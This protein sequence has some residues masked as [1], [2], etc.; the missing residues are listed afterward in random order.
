MAYIDKYTHE[1]LQASGTTATAN[2]PDHETDDLVVIFCTPKFSTFTT[3]TD[4]TLEEDCTNDGHMYLWTYVAGAT[5]KTSITMTAGSSGTSFSICCIVVKE[6]PTS[7]YVDLSAQKSSTAAQDCVVPSITT[8]VADCL[9]I[10]AAGASTTPQN[11]QAPCLGPGY[12][13]LGEASNDSQR[14][15][16]V[17]WTYQKSAGA[18]P[19]FDFPVSEY[20]VSNTSF[21]GIVVA[22]KDKGNS[23]YPGY[24]KCD[25]DANKPSTLVSRHGSRFEWGDKA[26]AVFNPTS[27]WSTINSTST[28]YDGD[29]GGQNFYILDDQRNPRMSSLT[30]DQYIMGGSD[31]TTA[32]DLS[33]S[34]L[35][36]TIAHVGTEYS[37]FAQPTLL[38]GLSNGTYGRLWDI[39]GSDTVPRLDRGIFPSTFEVDGGFE[40]SSADIGT[41][42]SAS[43]DKTVVAFYNNKTNDKWHIGALHKLQTLIMLG[44]SSTLPCSMTDA[45]KMIVACQ[46]NT[47][48]NQVGQSATQF[49]VMQ[50][51]TIGDGGTT[52]IY[53]DSTAQAIEFP[54]A[55]DETSA[56][57][58]VQNQISSA[59]L[60]LEVD[61][62]TGKTVKLGSLDMGDFH[63]ILITSGAVEVD[64]AV[65]RNSTPTIGTTDSAL[66]NL[67]I[68]ASKQLTL[69]GDIS[70]GG[71]VIDNCDDT[72]AVVVTSE[73]EFNAL[74][75]VDFTNNNYSIRIT[76]NHGGDTWIATGMTVSGGTGSYDIRYEGTGT[77]TIEVDTGS[78][79]TQ[80]R[81]EATTGTLTISAPTLSFT[82]NSSESGSD[83]KIFDT[84]TQTI[85]ASATGTTV[86]TT[87]TGTYDWTV[88]KAGFL[89]QRGTGVALSTSSVSVDV[90]LVEDPVYNASHGLTF[91]TDYSYTPATRILTIVAN[92]EGRDL[93]SALID[94]FISETSLRNVPFPLKA[95]GPDRIDFQAV[96][97][98]SSST[99]VGATIDSG[100]I[101]FWKGAGMEWEHD[102][103]GNPTKKFYS[104]KSANTLQ[105]GSVVGYTQVNNGTATETT[106][107]SDKVNE[108][109]QYFEDTDGNGTADYDYT[110]HLL[111][112]GFKTGFYQ[113]RWDVIND[114]GVS[115]L[116]SYEYVIN[117]IQDAI[118]G[119]TG[120]QSVTITTLTDHTS[121]PLSVGGKSFDYEL[122]DPASTT[123][124]DLLAQYNYDVFNA[125]DTSITSTLY[126]SYN[127]FDLPDL[128]IE[129]G[130]NYESERGYF[131]GDGAVT[132]LSGV[133][134]S[135]SGD[136]PDVARF[137]S[138]DGTYYTP[139]TVA[140]ISAPNITGTNR[141][142]IYNESAESFSAW[143][144]S[145]VYAEGA[146]VLRTTGQGTELG[147]G[148]F[149]VCT[150]AGTSGGSEPTWDVAADGNTTSDN[151]VT[152]TVRP[153]EFDNTSNVGAYSNTYT[154]GTYFTSG[155]T[156]RFRCTQT[157]KL[158]I[159]SSGVATAAGT[160]TFLDSATTDDVYVDSGLTG[161]DYTS[162]FSADY[163]DT[164]IDV[165]I[166]SNFQAIEMY[167]WFQYIL[168][169]EDGIRQF[170]GG[171]TAIDDSNFRINNGDVD[172]YFDNTTI[173]NIRQT[174]NRR[175]YRADEVYPVKGGGATTGGG[176]IDLVW[177]DKVFLKETGTSG[178]TA[179]ESSQLNSISTVE[180]KIDTVDTVVDAILVDTT[181][182]ETKVD[183]IDTNV[184]SI[185]IDTGTDIP[186]LIAAVQT[187]VDDIIADTGSTLP[188]QLSAISI[189]TTA[190]NT[191]VDQILTD[192]DVTIP[193]LISA[194]NDF[195]PS[196]DTLEG[197][198]T[199]DQTLRILRS[200]LAGKN[201]KVGNT[202]TFRDAADTKDRVSSEVV[203]KIRTSVTTDGT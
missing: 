120:D 151:T 102:T 53:W 141:I 192:T 155:D 190:T 164:E 160:T 36:I 183:T 50:D 172:V 142:Q 19:T 33:G 90:T 121:S 109:I 144:A 17:G 21:N 99:T 9:I 34:I 78:G 46:L 100:D 195:N 22:I 166:G 64:N 114:S 44:G 113:A 86:N 66:S 85:E 45:Q 23:Y 158:G 125:V 187:V 148:V 188:T 162:K 29:G 77:L 48:Q 73:S 10:A 119:T 115:S 96:G 26:Q 11:N 15:Q 197:S 6:A 156:I 37:A 146:R 130:A 143:A 62:G 60:T 131:E 122:V 108:V 72:Y 106:L 18:T 67:T 32:V 157:G 116:E 136:H 35:A 4:F 171:V 87:S 103:T 69:T 185:L 84:T 55:P 169:T 13:Y 79:W 173:T 196:S 105:T 154:N 1:D 118:A 107:V 75:N 93:Y 54:S 2:L 202:E 91:T 165:I 16:A 126:T 145:T 58:R 52:D 132:D 167:T 89:P 8:T 117:L 176:G 203:D 49:F 139:D 129:A 31:L 174:D 81:A 5:P 135:R 200:V 182:I 68:T 3:P 40:Y 150:G 20:R 201:N 186:A 70:G 71:C 184:D 101:Q 97:T 111:F 43:I 59:A 94:D 153:L 27:V 28:T 191:V 83:L 181:S 175:V 128:I 63:N 112:K 39:A 177:R 127:A 65:W 80:P 42:N 194:L 199:Y 198:E 161:S 179:S 123:A 12:G 88:Q 56:P 104:V 133:Y 47:I 30:A 92:Q 82:L 38:V 178:L 61:A 170:Y 25:S 51:M 147:D 193:G 41:F 74:R 57:I 149:F 124:E 159:T 14:C 168:T 95:I 7:A 134:I 163:T 138:N 180:S 76:G 98:F 152:W 140:Q 137:Q 24:C 189:T 110:G